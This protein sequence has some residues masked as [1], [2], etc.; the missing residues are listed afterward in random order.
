MKKHKKLIF[1]ILTVVLLLQWAGII[2]LESIRIVESQAQES[3]IKINFQSRDSEVS[4]GYIPDYGEVYGSKNGYTYGWN[5]SHEENTVIREVYSNDVIDTFSQFKEGGIWEIELTSGT[6]D[7]TV[8]VGDSVYSSNNSL[9]VE[10][11]AYW[12]NIAL[13]VGEFAVETKRIEVTDGKLTLDQGSTDDIGTKINYIEIIQGSLLESDG[14]G[15]KGEYYNGTNFEELI[16]N[17]TDEKIDFDWKADAPYHDMESDSFSIRWE[18]KVE[19]RFSQTYTFYTE[20]H[21]GVRLWVDDQ[22]L[23]DDWDAHSMIEK[24]GG[25]E[26]T[27]GEKYDIK[28][29]YTESSGSASAKLLW[30]S[31]SEEKEIIPK[32]QLAPPFI[33]NVPSNIDSSAASTTITITWDDVQGATGYDIEVDGTIVNNGNSTTY[34]HDELTPNTQHSYRVRSKVPGVVSNWSK[35]I[36]EIAKINVPQ[37]VN[38]SLEDNDITVTW[39]EVSGAVSYEIEVDGEV[40]DNEQSTQYVHNDLMP[41]T[42]HTYRV[43]AKNSN[44]VGDWSNL[45]TRTVPTDIP[46]NIDVIIDYTSIELTWNEVSGAIGYEVEVDGTIIDNLNNTNFVHN[47]LEPNTQHSYRIRAVKSD[48]VSDWS[49]T[50]VKSTLTQPGNGTGLKGEYFDN[51]DFTDYK[52]ARIDENIN[53][54]WKKK[55]PAEGVDGDEFST[56]WTGQIEPM[57]SETYTFYTETHGGVKLWVDNELVIDDWTAHNTTHMNGSIYLKSGKR[58]DIKMEY[59]ESNGVAK[60]ELYWESQTQVKEII[61]QSQLY[62]IGIPQ[63]ITLIAT[64]TSITVDWDDVTYAESYEI[65][66]DG[67]VVDNGSSSSYIHNNLNPGTQHTYRVRAKNDFIIGE[68]SATLTRTTLIGMPSNIEVP[69]ATETNIT[70]VWDSVEGATGY[71]IELDGKITNVGDYTTYIHENLMTGTLHSYRVRAKTDVV[72]GDWTNS[73]AKWTIP[74]KPREVEA[75]AIETQIEITWE[76]VVGATVYDIEIDGEIRADVTSPYTHGELLSGTEHK[77]RVRAKN[78]SGLGKWSDELTKWTIPDVPSFVDITD[79]TENEITIIWDDNVR[80][81]T[82]YDI[83]IDGEIQMNVKSPYIHSELLSGIE[84][85]YRIRAKNSSGLGKWS[86]ELTIWTLPDVPQNI[87]ITP[88]STSLTVAWDEVRGATG[89]EL[90]IFDTVIDNGTSIEYLHGGLSPNTQ[91]IYRVR[92]KNPSGIGK[93]SSVIAKTTLPDRPNNITTSATDTTITVTWDAVAGVTGYD[94]EIDESLVEEITESSYMHSGLMP[95]TSHK[96]RIRTKNS[97][98]TSNWS[99]YITATTVPSTPTNLSAAITDSGI[100]VT[101]DEVDGATGYDIEVDG[102]VIDNGLDTSYNHTN[103]EPN[104][105]H[106]YR[107]R[108]RNGKLTSLWSAEIKKTTLLDIPANLQGIATSTEITISWDVVVGAT[109]Y[110]IEVDD[111]IVDNGLSTTFIHS[112]LTPNTEHTYRVRARSGAGVGEWSEAITKITLLG[113]PTN[114]IA[115]S[116]SKSITISWDAVPG[117]TAYEVFVDGEVI[118]NGLSTT[119]IHDGLEPNTWHVYRVRAK[120]GT[121][122]GDWSDGITWAT[123]VGIPTKIKAEATSTEITITWDEVIGATAYEIEVDGTVIDNDTLTTYI[124]VGLDPN[125]LH[126][127]RVRAKNENGPSD[128]SALLFQ[129]TAPDIPKNLQA[130]ATTTEINITWDEVAGADN[131]DIEVDGEIVENIKELSYSHTELEPNTWHIYRVRAKNS[132][133]T[134]EWSEELQQNTN[135]E[136][137]VNVGKDTTFNFV[138][139]APK[140]A[141]VSTRSIVVNYNPDE[142]EVVDLCAVTP[143]MNLKTGKIEGTNIVVTEFSP[144]EI[145]Y[146]ISDADRT[147]VNS[148]KF[149]AKVNEHSKITYVV[150]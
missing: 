149:M 87:F 111:Q 93:W 15:L 113:I 119:Y 116:T 84:H 76:N 33:P 25:I 20:T 36:S 126:A 70:V 24:S 17:R 60:S 143:E 88:A 27:A 120:S 110:D 108:A 142:V 91:Y 44:G 35:T 4:D 147:V 75:E 145:K 49:I 117:A 71:D 29:E 78:S 138:I 53:F 82:G 26:L 14:I 150:E 118:D 55:D 80:G 135:Q 94:I 112:E 131:Y 139:V 56:R 64:E 32:E 12:D 8:S 86:S 39:D 83:E 19:P 22:L 45:I 97:D 74:D 136:I 109:G 85:R 52:L 127:Y 92:A 130:T 115:T 63:N 43:R 141:D 90:E 5:T 89:Y 40:I 28:M 123:L 11:I 58:Y 62:P 107:V 57:Y 30:S 54:D 69:E 66:V 133:G 9:N 148:I 81:A 31:L 137:A 2:D 99:E 34:V 61:P 103:I 121:F 42:D 100:T 68:W 13:G 21:G 122:A 79:V 6:Y 51:N 1:S 65:E 124:H 104:T 125:T 77:Y 129:L 128:W 59:C 105:E 73:V 146:T 18:G 140:K 23:I 95:N 98:G 132:G 101:W 37:N 38:V 114:L 41:S 46:T 72:T 3:N 7:V 96:Y 67:V 16:E 10:G 50:I 134:S 48:G 144:G 47:D 102:V 106:T